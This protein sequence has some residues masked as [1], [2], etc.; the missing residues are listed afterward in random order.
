[1]LYV[2]AIRSITKIGVDIVAQDSMKMGLV[3]LVWK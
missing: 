1:M 2:L 3:W